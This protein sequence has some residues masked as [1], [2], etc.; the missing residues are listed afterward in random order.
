VHFTGPD[1][2]IPNRG[3]D[4]GG[5]TRRRIGREKIFP[6]PKV[7][8]RRSEYGAPPERAIL[9]GRAAP[10]AGMELAFQAA[11]PI[12]FPENGIE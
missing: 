6:L 10:I 4:I 7:R 8:A 11:Q 12:N 2:R 1:A 9:D 3:D 5:H